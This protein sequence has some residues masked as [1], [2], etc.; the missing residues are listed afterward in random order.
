MP[1]VARQGDRDTGGGTLV[2]NYSSDVFVNGKA[3]AHVGTKQSAHPPHPRQPVHGSS[4]IT[5]GS[6]TVFVNGKAVAYVCSD[7]LCGHKIAS[8]SENVFVG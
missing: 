8:G 1:N 6:S 7:T 5:V 4:H 2:S 3:M